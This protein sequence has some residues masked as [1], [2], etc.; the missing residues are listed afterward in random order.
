MDKQLM[1]ELLEIGKLIDDLDELIL[2]NNGGFDDK[3][4]NHIFTIERSLDKFN[5]YELTSSLKIIYLYTEANYKAILRGMA[6]TGF[7]KLQLSS[8]WVK[9]YTSYDDFLFNNYIQRIRAYREALRLTEANDKLN[10]H[11]ISQIYVNL[12]NVY[13]EMGR[14]VEAI[15]ELKNVEKL[16]GDFPM[17]RGNLAIKHFSLAQRVTDR[18]IMRFLIEKGFSELKIVCDE[19]TSDMIPIDALEMFYDWEK[20]MENVLDTNLSDVESWSVNQ[21]VDDE[22]KT[23][24][25]QNNLSLNY[26]NVICKKG[27]IDDV[28]MINMGMGYFGTE[29]NMEYYSWFNTIKQEYNMA[30][31]F[32]YQIE[33]SDTTSLVHESQRYNILINTLDYPAIGFKTELLKVALKTAFSVLDKIGLFCCKF[34]NQSIPTHRIDFHKWY[35]EIEF[36]VALDGPFNALYWL[37]KDLDL[38]NGEFKEIRLLRNCIE[39][40]FIRILDYYD[41]PLID[42]L[43]DKDKYEYTISYTDLESITFTTLH[44]VRTAIFYMASGFNIE[45]NRF[46]YG[47]REEKVF[48]PLLLGTY[49]D[50]WK[51]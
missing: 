24:S 5:A 31:Y 34:H 19:A 7:E 38:K 4:L 37:S 41:T 6:D 15:Q 13:I 28:Q 42:E 36:E 43:I 32:L 46:Y 8:Q 35:K 30:R 50:E 17:A 9:K 20:Y 44:L 1:N 45:F 47:D 10:L 26:I 27:N 18:K 39:H 3:Y 29:R 2:S 16:V 21:D 25:A 14:V 23:W 49:D 40:R 22:Y 33:N 12:A 48:I 51:N 11:Y